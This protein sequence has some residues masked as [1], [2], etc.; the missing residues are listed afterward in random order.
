[1][2]TVLHQWREL[3]VRECEGLTIRLEWREGSDAV[4]INWRD[5]RR[6]EVGI[7]PV[8]ADKAL[9]AFRHPFFY[10]PRVGPV[11]RRLEGR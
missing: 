3:M 4:R 5:E 8:P 6:Q 10:S 7:Y 11:A 2:T 1:M 9:D